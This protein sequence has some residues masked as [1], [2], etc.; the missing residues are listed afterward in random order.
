MKP[1]FD[2]EDDGEDFETETEPVSV[3][4]SNSNSLPLTGEGTRDGA[5]QSPAGR[6][7]LN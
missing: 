1:F 2:D 3:Q 5:M 4:N 7:R 6:Y